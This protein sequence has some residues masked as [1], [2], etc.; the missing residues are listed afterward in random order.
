MPE[1]SNDYRIEKTR[2][3]VSMTLMSGASIDGALFVQ[4]SE[5]YFGALEDAPE[6]LNHPEPF[7]PFALDSGGTTIVAKDNVRS[8][9]T[10]Q[11]DV[12]DDAG[13]GLATRVEVTLRDGA[14][15]TGTVFVEPISGSSRLL[16]FLNRHTERFVTLF[17]GDTVILLNRTLLERVRLLP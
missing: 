7:F 14:V 16:D 11:Q 13:M 1:L 5:H 6:V 15:L 12:H 3:P 17:R 8:L 10:N 2:L 4:S 9:T